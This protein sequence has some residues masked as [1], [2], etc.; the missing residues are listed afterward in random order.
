[1]YKEKKGM[2]LD[3]PLIPN[4]L[5]GFIFFLPSFVSSSSP[6]LGNGDMKTFDQRARNDLKKC[7]NLSGHSQLVGCVTDAAAFV[8]LPLI[9]P[10]TLR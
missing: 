4:K 3:S 9:P 2:G 8:L 5:P 10:P 6:S 7:M 1:M